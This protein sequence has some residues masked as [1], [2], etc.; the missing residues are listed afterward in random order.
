MQALDAEFF[1]LR[2]CGVSCCRMNST[3]I[4][5][6]MEGAFDSTTGGKKKKKKKK[7]KPV[8]MQQAAKEENIKT[9]ELMADGEVQQFATPSK[10]VNK[11]PK[12]ITEKKLGAKQG[13]VEKPKKQAS[14]EMLQLA[15]PVKGNGK[16]PAKTPM[17][18]RV[19]TKQGTV[20]KPRKT[21][22]S[23]VK[24]HSNGLNIEDITMGKSDGKQAK[25]GKRVFCAIF[26]M[27]M[28]VKFLS[29]SSGHKFLG[30]S[31]LLI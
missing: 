30:H 15:V 21:E 13:T 25:P 22:S 23:A 17:E 3:Q 14:W 7:E 24:K 5:L 27:D 29:S 12:S 4:P 31:R 1:F 10:G 8:K 20:V 18:E 16:T 6:E 28:H 9:Y 2:I 26:S 11:I 19:A